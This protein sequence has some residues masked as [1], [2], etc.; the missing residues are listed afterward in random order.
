MLRVFAG[1]TENI[2]QR[3]TLTTEGDPHL[4]PHNGRPAALYADGRNR[5]QWYSQ[6]SDAHHKRTPT[7]NGLACH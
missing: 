1:V 5:E 4:Q 2:T 6:R 7:F 3:L